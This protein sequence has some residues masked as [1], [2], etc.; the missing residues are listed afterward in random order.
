[1]IIITNSSMFCIQNWYCVF[2]WCTLKHGHHF[3]SLRAVFSSTSMRAWAAQPALVL[4]SS[5]QHKEWLKILNTPWASPPL[6]S[7]SF[8]SSSYS[9]AA[10]QKDPR[11]HRERANKHRVR[12]LPLK[13][14]I[15][16]FHKNRAIKSCAT[17]EL[18]PLYQPKHPHRLTP[19]CN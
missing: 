11:L 12:Q 18:G 3:L 2:P 19:A 17:D 15:C 4:Y 8:S 5:F 7:S 1:M 6:C 10:S 13:T 9:R 14:R 16:S